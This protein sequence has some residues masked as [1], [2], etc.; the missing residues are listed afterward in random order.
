M[1]PQLKHCSQLLW[2]REN[3]NRLNSCKEFKLLHGMLIIIMLT[4]IDISLKCSFV[5]VLA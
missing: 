1:P 2:K 5:L 3:Q 4:L